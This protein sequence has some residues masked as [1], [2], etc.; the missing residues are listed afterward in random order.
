MRIT[1]DLVLI[2]IM[3]VCMA[4]GG[5]LL[6]FAMPLAGKFLD[7]GVTALFVFIARR[8]YYLPS[9]II[10]GRETDRR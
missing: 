3:A 5:L 7:L 1:F 10:T 9:W 2:A 6:D 8:L 4:C